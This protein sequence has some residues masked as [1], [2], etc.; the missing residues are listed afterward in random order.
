MGS[1]KR[2][3][4]YIL[5]YIRIRILKKISL[6]FHGSDLV[7]HFSGVHDF[8][9][10]PN[11]ANAILYFL[12]FI[13]TVDLTWDWSTHFFFSWMF[14]KCQCELKFGFSEKHT[15]FEKKIL[16]MVWTFT[17]LSKCTKLKEDCANFCV[18]LRKSELYL[19][20]VEIIS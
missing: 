2:Y 13:F 12:K 19:C 20:L 6:Y 10:C 16:V 3:P 18:L 17:Y 1:Q 7:W 4:L 8:N 5:G 11:L 15:K 9:S 14:Y